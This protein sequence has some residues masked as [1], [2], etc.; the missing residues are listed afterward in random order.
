M[1]GS[2]RAWT[3]RHAFASSSLPATTKAVLHTLGM[4]MNELGEG[5]YPSVADICRYSGLD[6]KTVLKHLGTARD[7]GWIAVSQHG[8]RGQRWK[9]QE[10]SARWPERDL[11]SACP[12]ADDE[13]GGGNTPP[14]SE[15]SDAVD[16]VPEGGGNEGSKVVEH[17]HQDKTSPVNIPKNSPS[18][19]AH[20]HEFSKG[21]DNQS[22]VTPEDNP[23]SAAF[24]K[25]VLKF[26]EGEGYTAGV[27]KGWKSSS[28]T[29]IKARFSDLSVSERLE[30]ERWRDGYLLDMA[31]QKSNPQPVGV[32]LRD[33]TWVHLD[34]IL[35]KRA[36]SASS[37]QKKPDGWA[38]CLGPVG[39]ARLFAFLIDGP[40][41]SE[42]A[43]GSFLTDDMLRRT[44]PAVHGFKSLIQMKGGTVFGERWRNLAQ[45]FEPV[46]QDTQ[47]L[48]L[49]K[50]EFRARGWPWL[51]AFDGAAVVY[52]PKGGPDGLNGFETA[53]RG[54]GE[55][56]GN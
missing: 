24:E 15:A 37:G 45:L 10:Y 50:E 35:L 42:H 40:E 34:E 20:E 44:W 2:S 13:K 8:Y 22:N 43:N 38:A 21:G 9:R 5:C 54:L 6:K 17:V 47:M 27:W 55:N 28:L 53:L 49:W 4:F 56:D 48:S 18:E 51:S 14:P 30:A 52:C 39:M 36:E 11:L 1:S 31:A 12:P 46:P 19:R 16:F 23:K 29:W 41:D 26:V 25:R 3:W 7:A 32:F 33:R